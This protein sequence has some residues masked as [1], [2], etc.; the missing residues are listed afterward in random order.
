[1]GAAFAHRDEADLGER[2]GGLVVTGPAELRGVGGGVG[3]IEHQT[4]DGHHPQAM[5]PRPPGPGSGHRYRDPLEQQPQRGRTEPGASL[6][7]CTR[8]RHRPVLSPVPQKSQPVHQL[9]DHLFVRFT[10]EQIQRQH[11]VHHHVSR[12]QP[13]PNLT[14]PAFADHVIHDIPMNHTTQH[15]EGHMVGQPTR[16]RSRNP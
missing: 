11:V 15:P 5:E 16:Y 14:F 7:N 13:R 12:Q 3:Y 6:R 4:V 10:E 2:A 1:V 9:A 8:G